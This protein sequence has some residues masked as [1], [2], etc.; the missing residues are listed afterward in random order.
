MKDKVNVYGRIIV[1]ALK[2]MP[3]REY[4]GTKDDMVWYGFHEYTGFRGFW[5]KV[6][7][8]IKNRIHEHHG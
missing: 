1:G 5:R 2:L 8:G 3:H 6:R 7:M 4:Q